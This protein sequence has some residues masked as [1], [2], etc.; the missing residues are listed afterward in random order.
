[1]TSEK[2]P[3]EQVEAM[4]H[5]VLTEGHRSRLA[6]LPGAHRCVTCSIP[7]NGIG[8]GMVRMLGHRPSRKNPSLCNL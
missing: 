8:G 7:L 1:M 4:W 2:S 3:Q 6:V 5:M